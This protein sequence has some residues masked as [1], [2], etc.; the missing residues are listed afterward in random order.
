MLFKNQAFSLFAA[1][2][3]ALGITGCGSSNVN[4]GV[5]AGDG[6]VVEPSV[7]IDCGTDSNNVCNYKHPVDQVELLTL[8]A[9]PAAGA[10]FKNWAAGGFPCAGIDPECNIRFNNLNYVGKA[11]FSSA[12]NSEFENTNVIRGFYYCPR[13]PNTI[14]VTSSFMD[15]A[16]P[17]PAKHP[18]GP[19]PVIIWVTGGYWIGKGN[20]GGSDGFPAEFLEAADKG[21]VSVLIDTASVSPLH[22]EKWPTQMWDAKGAVR[23]V[24]ANAQSNG[25]R[26]PIDVN[27]IAMVGY[28]SGGQ[29]ALLTGLTKKSAEHGS[30]YAY[31]ESG[32]D[33]SGMIKLGFERDKKDTYYSNP[34]NR[35]YRLYDQNI[36]FAS[37]VDLVVSW[38]APT[39]LSI[40]CDSYPAA[41]NTTA[42][43]SV[44]RLFGMSTYPA[45]NSPEMGIAT[46]ASPVAYLDGTIPDGRDIPIMV[47]QGSKDTLVTPY[48]G[49]AM[50]DAIYGAYGGNT[51]NLAKNYHYIE[52]NNEGHV[53]SAAG[54]EVAKNFTFQFIDQHFKGSNTSYSCSGKNC[55]LDNW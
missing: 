17:D 30:Q 7:G 54:R 43:D 55:T 12:G 2:M 27:R 22:G 34:G 45:I 51:Q 25:G 21:Y 42:V 19:Y 38:S 1:G 16:W 32:E 44:K 50:R 31:P 15:V 20:R 29:L 6:K 52:L 48:H 8:D 4:V 24:R 23:W 39:D 37:D 11:V 36:E 53:Y 47:I 28:S 35:K 46:E 18:N 41:C 49:E 26:L 10:I 3:I 5:N 33:Q 13:Y 9:E 40:D 14:S